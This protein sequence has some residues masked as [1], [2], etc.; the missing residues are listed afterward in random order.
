MNVNENYALG[1]QNI[2]N[3]L[4]Q[5]LIQI[6]NLAQAK[7]VTLFTPIHLQF[8]STSW[9]VSDKEKVFLFLYTQSKRTTEKEGG[10]TSSFNA[11]RERVR[12]EC[13]SSWIPF[14]KGRRRDRWEGDKR[15]RGGK[16]R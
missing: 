15:N 8:T 5:I 3:T 10:K 16:R 7:F 9:S 6:S 13:H 14:Q 2:R 4:Y 1:V 12:T 11:R